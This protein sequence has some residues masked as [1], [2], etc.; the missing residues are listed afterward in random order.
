MEA[1]S[2]SSCAF[3][4]GARTGAERVAVE[5]RDRGNAARIVRRDELVRDRDYEVDYDRGA[6]LLRQPVP[7]SDPYGNP[8]FVVVAFERASGGPVRF[9]G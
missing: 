7:T 1:A 2:C 3:G 5:V 6:V 9:V 8:V 4:T